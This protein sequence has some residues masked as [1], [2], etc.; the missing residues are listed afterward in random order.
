MTPDL[1]KALLAPIS[2]DLPSGS[3][4][5]YSAECDQIQKL[6]KGDDPSLAQG[7]WVREIR[8]P[9]WPKVRE[10]C[11]TILT[12]RSK[13]LQVACWYLEAL[14]HLEGFAGMGFG[15]KVADAMLTRFWETC[16]PAYTV[17]DPEER[18]AKL[19]WL[20]SQ[21]P[22][23]VRNIPMT[24]TRVG[25]FSYLKWEESR[26]VENLG[27]RDPKGKDQ[28]IADGKLSGEAF[29]KAA[30]ASG[31]GFYLG[32][33]EQ[34]MGARAAFQRFEQTIDDRFGQ[35]AP[36]LERLR[37]SLGGCQDLAAQVLRRFGLEPEEQVPP[38][39]AADD[40]EPAPGSE[41]ESI[42]DTFSA[43]A[44]LFPAPVAS[45][46]APASAVGSGPLSSRGEAIFRLREIAEFFREHEPHSPVGPLVE[47]AA[48][49]GEMPLEQWL[50]K[51]IKDES[52]LVHLRE[53]L[54]LNAEQ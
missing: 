22:Q 33:H 51:V 5:T 7:E 42:F 25:G 15:L 35:D 47:R 21:V 32:L 28:A 12:T 19:E 26:T 30:S 24:S 43:P 38:A 6:R 31:Q 46:P 37:E 11:E 34:I 49:W 16:F 29:D 53:L 1:F 23:V 39:P 14:T 52:T 13:D 41:P 27:I 8:T 2:P 10:L 50:T 48:R 36:G 9:E 4:V 40:A 54:D 20:N 17:S 45:R 44:P 3:E 18:I